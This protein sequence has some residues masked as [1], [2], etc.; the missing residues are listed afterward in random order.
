VDSHFQNNN[1]W[2]VLFQ[3]ST[4]DLLLQGTLIDHNTTGG[5]HINNPGGV[6]EIMRNTIVANAGAGIQIAN[7]SSARIGGA[8][9]DGNNLYGN[10]FFQLQNLNATVSV[11]AS[12]NWWGINPPIPAGISGLVDS[13]SP[14][15]APAANAPV[16]LADIMLS[17]PNI[18]ASAMVNDTIAYTL[19]FTNGGPRE[20]YHLVLSA[21]LPYPAELLTVSGSGW[22]CSVD[23]NQ[24][25]CYLPYLA[26]DGVTEITFSI[27]SAVPSP[28]SFDVSI[29]Q[30][31][32]DPLTQN[33]RLTIN[34]T[35]VMHMLLPLVTK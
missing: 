20:A 22:D 1:D 26:A 3:S 19:Y 34:T 8:D 23:G 15:T 33:N 12:H 18:P 35:I 29:S 25:T 13:T 7:E 4:S 16:Y 14:L 2:G 11:N 30:A 10:Q 17:G 21:T 24:F 5:L 6:T 31:N 9:V 32:N 27:R 28:L